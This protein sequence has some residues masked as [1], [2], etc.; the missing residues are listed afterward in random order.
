MSLLPY[1]YEVEYLESTGTQWIDTGLALV[2]SADV[3]SVTMSEPTLR[4]NGYAWGC[5]RSGATSYIRGARFY[6]NNSGVRAYLDYIGGTAAAT[7]FGVAQ[8]GE[9][10]QFVCDFPNTSWTCKS[11]SGTFGP[12]G[13]VN[14]NILLFS[15]GLSDALTASI[16]VSNFAVTRSGNAVIDL[17]PVVANGEACMYDRVSG[18]LFGNSGTGAFVAGPRIKKFIP[19]IN[20]WGGTKSGRTAR[21]YVQDGL[22]AMWDGIENAGWGVHDDT[23]TVWM[24]LVGGISP[25]INGT[26]ASDHVNSVG[27]MRVGSYLNQ[28]FGAGTS[29][30][31]E[32]VY[33]RGD[34]TIN[35]CGP[36]Y[37]GYQMFNC[38]KDASSK[39]YI[40]DANGTGQVGRVSTA[41]THSSYS[42]DAET[43]TVIAYING[44]EVINKESSVFDKSVQG[45]NNTYI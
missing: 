1:D 24:D 2:E 30:S 5:R 29:F 9:L 26:I 3:V 18:Q 25:T 39:A 33:D 4:A 20:L 35:F 45:N 32:C 27:Q 12:K 28:Y 41:R 19:L 17:I 16:R 11:E 36:F 22:V 14:T 6:D 10:V 13:T 23:A 37:V 42:R 15:S 44:L 43:R 38:Y 31:I 21:D 8:V 40:G 34:T 7:S